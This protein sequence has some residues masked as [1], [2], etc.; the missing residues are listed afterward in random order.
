M[1]FSSH[2]KRAILLLIPEG[3]FSSKIKCTKYTH[4]AIKKEQWI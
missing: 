2:M 3:N 4:S 1:I